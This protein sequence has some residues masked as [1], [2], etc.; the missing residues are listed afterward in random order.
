MN[1]AMT[2]GT[3][4]GTQAL[5]A[6]WRASGAD[7][8]DPVRYRLM[9]AMAR[10]AA[11]HDG[12]ARQRIDERLGALAAAYA[13][14]V[15][16][17]AGAVPATAARGA[18]PTPPASPLAAL[19]RQWASDDAAPRELRGVQACRET[20]AGLRAERRLATA[21]ADA[22]THAGPLN[23]HQLVHRALALMQTL[24]P[25]YLACFARQVDALLQIDSL[26]AAA[27]PPAPAAGARKGVRRRAG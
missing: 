21:L 9:E 16:E 20:F 23:S 1:P 19:V 8:L 14:R 2:D 26:V 12:P 15:D 5:L 27:Q 22:P 24:S 13:R 3:L 7:R 25:G 11:A 10:R 18:A 4:P 17:A 6:Q